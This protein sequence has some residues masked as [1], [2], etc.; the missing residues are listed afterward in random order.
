[1]T[2]PTEVSGANSLRRSSISVFGGLAISIGYMGPTAGIAIIPA[3]MAG[4]I[5][6]AGVV[7]FAV[8]LVL[9]LCIAYSF[10]LFTRHF[11]HAGSVYQYN[12]Q[13][14]GAAYGFVS[15]WILFFA[16]TLFCVATAAQTASY[17]KA[18]WSQTSGVPWLIFTLAV[19]AIAVFLTAR[20]IRLSAIFVAIVEGVGLLLVLIVGIA[21]L[22]H[23]GFHG[24]RLTSGF[25]DISGFP[26]HTIALGA[27]L[28]FLGFT[29]FEA[30]STLSEETKHAFKNVPIA[31]VA[32]LVAAAIAYIYGDLIE[33]AAFANSKAL[34]NSSA[35]LLYASSHYLSS[36]LTPVLGAATVLSAFGAVVAT[37]NGATRLLFA[38][39][40]DGFIST[41]LGQTSTSKQ[42][43]T[44]ALAMVAG[45][46]V[47][48]VAAQGF[49]TP[50]NVFSYMS[51]LGTLAELAMYVMTLAAAVIF[52]RRVARRRSWARPLGF[53]VLIVGIVGTGYGLYTTVW[54]APPFP[55]NILT[56]VAA[57]WLVLG[58]AIIVL[59]PGLRHRL[60][61][62][63]LLR[64]EKLQDP[65]ELQ[66]SGETS[67]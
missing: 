34:A 58:V 21:V 54:P 26:V 50:T 57:G 22:S 15:V 27:I 33:T 42:T 4:Y 5:G 20:S 36:S 30:A 65:E 28:A 66:P 11:I 47:V 61:Q 44:T 56:Y 18:T 23:G 64:L 45:I 40:R 41:R 17:I 24:T 63:S 32:S 46:V 31:I 6:D 8:G 38:L 48:V 9:G 19:I 67:R 13:A 49:D 3:I 60:A 55:L 12:G 14:L 62:S 10:I 39:G 29:G 1:V 43:P 16:Y 53:A 52:L 7:G 2:E 35:P 25:F 59:R 37:M 51:T